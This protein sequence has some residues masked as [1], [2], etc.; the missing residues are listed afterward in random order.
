[1][2]L[3]DNLLSSAPVSLLNP[4]LIIF[5]P[6]GVSSLVAPT[7]LDAAAPPPVLYIGDVD[8]CIT[9]LLEDIVSSLSTAT[10]CTM[11]DWRPNERTV[12]S[13]AISQTAVF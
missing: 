9:G 8:L 5:V 11:S 3:T 2:V 13:A 7:L 12:S 6:V 1:M 4:P 10:M